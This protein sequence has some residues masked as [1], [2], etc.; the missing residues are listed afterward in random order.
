MRGRR[1]V[2]KIVEELL[3][4]ILQGPIRIGQLAGLGR[5]HLQETVVS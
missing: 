1:L 3:E 4:L 2:L 5:G